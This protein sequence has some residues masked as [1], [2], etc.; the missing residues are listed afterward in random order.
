LDWFK[1]PENIEARGRKVHFITDPVSH[2]RRCGTQRGLLTVE[3]KIEE[4]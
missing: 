4:D 3:L 2:Q 1:A